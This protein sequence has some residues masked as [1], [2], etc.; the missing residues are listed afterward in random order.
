MQ[1]IFRN[2]ESKPARE[3]LA[4]AFGCTHCLWQALVDFTKKAFPT[5]FEEWKFTNA[6]YGWSYRISDKKRVLIYLLP[7]DKFFKAAFVFGQK[8][9]DEIY[10][11]NVSG[12]IKSELRNAKVY[13]E[14][15]G[16]RIE[17]K[18]ES[19]MNDLRELIKIKISN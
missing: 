1:S 15:R 6:K 12:V 18:D 5:A 16:I 9:T 14:G 4:E 3:N 19:A 17:E 8:A 2:K 11:S 13:A 7:R 10:E